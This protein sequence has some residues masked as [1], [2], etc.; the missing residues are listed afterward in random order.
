MTYELTGTIKK[1]LPRQDFPS[2]FYKQEVVVTTVEDRF[3][4]DIKLDCLREKADLL[5]NFKEGDWVKVSFDLRGREWNERYFVDLTVWKLEAIPGK[6]A[7]PVGP[8]VHEP[9]RKAQAVPAAEE[10]GTHAIE[11][12]EE[13][14]F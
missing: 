9:E 4:Q 8:P 10:S 14:P 5:Q 11:E 6:T 2:G 13:I 7:A 1:I 3:P 12:D